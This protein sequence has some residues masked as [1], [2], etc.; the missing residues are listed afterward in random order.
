MGYELLYNS[1]HLHRAG[2]A[3]ARIPTRLSRQAHS[4]A[5]IF[6]I[7]RLTRTD[8]FFRHDWARAH[9]G[10]TVSWPRV[11]KHMGII[12]IKTLYSQ[13]RPLVTLCAYVPLGHLKDSD[14]NS[15]IGAPLL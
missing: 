12:N 11:L 5:W 10:A 9:L 6:F 2:A 15:A 1:L 14:S 8:F 13:S 7:Y 4:M 3:V